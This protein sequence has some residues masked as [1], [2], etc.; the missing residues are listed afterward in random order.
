MSIGVATLT[1]AAACR[2]PEP[3]PVEAPV[4]L[5]ASTA[6]SVEQLCDGGLRSWGVLDDEGEVVAITRGRCLGAIE[7]PEDGELW[8]FVAQLQSVDEPRPAWDLHLWLGDDRLPRFAE[9]RQPTRVTRYAWHDEGMTV[10]RFGD[11]LDLGVGARELWP[12][13]AHGLFVR[14]LM[15]RAGVGVE[16]GA[17][18]Q[19]SWLPERDAATE[20]ALSFVRE[21]DRAE[22]RSE[23]GPAMVLEGAASGVR[24]LRITAV[25]ADQTLR[26]RP[27]PSGSDAMASFL[28]ARPMPAYAPPA[29]L[30]LVAV[31][32][33][34][35]GEHP[36]LGA[37]LVMAP[38][39]SGRRPAVLFL[40][41]AGPQDRHGLVPGSSVD[42]G[43]HEIHDALARAGFVVLRFDDRGVGGSEVGDNPTPGFDDL[44][45]D[46]RRAWETLAAR[47]EVDPSRI[48][49][50]G[51]GEGALQASILAAESVR[52]RGKRR[53]L[54]GLITMAAPGRNLRELIYDEI[55]FSLDGQRE[56]QVRTVVDRARRVHD[57]ALAGD[58]LPASSEGARTWMVEAFREDP[59]ARLRAVNV[60]ILALQG[61]KDFQVSPE[62]DFEAVR[63]IVEGKRIAGCEVISFAELDHLF[64]HEPGRSTPGHYADLDRRVDAEVVAAIVRWAGERTR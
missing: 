46:G 60:P 12:T 17:V 15:F 31:D 18:L 20:L 11:Q 10:R 53:K 58:D 9:F 57:A 22:A 42:I 25:L 16:P 47:P 38:D 40:G 26:Y 37:E 59:L 33:P 52:V 54:A 30:E 7:H 24:A 4:T 19:R 34:A 23:G 64:K 62:R 39:G 41:G 6:A 61:G 55:R 13:P 5:D 3:S 14:E 36:R 8:H 2:V 27:L 50:V 35:E 51:H 49:I 32:V 21:G 56:G 44:V 28:P 1:L 29:D 43:S 63:G 45:H 48:V